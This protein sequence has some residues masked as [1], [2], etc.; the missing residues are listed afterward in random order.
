MRSRKLTFLP[1]EDRLTP[2]VGDL[3][4]TLTPPGGAVDFG[5]SVAASSQYVVVGAD[6]ANSWAG[7]AAVYDA[8][9]GARLWTFNDPAGITDDY[10]GTSVAVSG[11]LV[12]V[13]APGDDTSGKDTGR[14]YV[15]DATTGNLVSTLINPSPDPG[16]NPAEGFGDAV[17]ITGDTIFVSADEDPHPTLYSGNVYEF[18][19]STGNYLGALTP[20]ASAEGHNFGS[21]LAVTSSLLAVAASSEGNFTEGAVH[22]YDVATGNLLRTI[23]EPG[24]SQGVFD[25][26]GRSLSFSGT[27]LVI[28]APKRDLSGTDAGIAY[29]FDA[30]TGSLLQTLNNPHPASG[31]WF[32]HG[33]AI[34]GNTVIVGAPYDNTQASNN[35]QAYVFDASSGGV[36]ATIPNPV[37]SGTSG[38]GWSAAAASDKLVAGAYFSGNAYT[39]QGRATGG[40]PPQANNDTFQVAENSSATTL[41]V[42][43][44][45]TAD[46]AKLLTVSAITQPTHGSVTIS[47]DNK[48][49]QYTP[50]ANYIGADSFTYTAMDPNGSSTA[51]V[52]ITVEGPPQPKDDSYDVLENSSASTLDVL[53]ND[54]AADPSALT[55]SAVTQPSHGTVSISADSKSVTYKP[56][57]YYNGPDSFTYTA[58]D[59]NGSTIATVNITVDLV[60]NPP[61]AQ[62]DE[63]TVNQDSGANSLDVLAND[64]DPDYGQTVSVTQVTQGKHGTV[65][66]T[67][68]GTGL[69]YAPNSGYVGPD[70][71]TYTVSDGH[72]GTASTNVIVSVQQTGSS[73][74]PPDAKDDSAPNL[75]ENAGAQTID[76]LAN[77][78]DPDAADT[79]TV[80]TVTQGQHGTVAIAADGKSVTYAPNLEFVGSDSFLYS[81][82]DGHGGT[83]Y[84]AVTVTVNTDLHDRLEI[85]TS[86][87]ILTF[88]EGN[89][90]LQLDGGIRVSTNNTGIKK[91]QIKIT[92][93]YVKGRDVLTFTPQK[94]LKGSFSSATGTLT[95]SGLPVATAASAVNVLEGVKYKNA[96]ADPVAGV[97]T[98]AFTASD[99]LG[100]GDPAYRT[101]NVIAKNTPPTIVVT[102]SALNYKENAPALALTS[103][104]KITDLDNV[105]LAGATVAITGGFAMG[106]DVLSVA[107][108]PGIAG[109]YD[110]GS[111]S[112]TLTGTATLATYAN[113][114]KS[115]KYANT[116]DGPS[117]ATRTISFTATDGL[118]TSLAA[119]R[120]V[121]VI[122]V[123]DAPVLDGS[124]N[125][126][127]PN[128]NHDDANPAGVTVAAL[129]G[130]SVTDPDPGALQGIAVTSFTLVGGGTWQYSVDGTNWLNISFLNGKALLLAATDEIRYLPSGTT[131]GS[132]TITCRAWDQTSGRAGQLVSIRTE[133]GTSA[134]SVA[135][136][137]ATVGV[138]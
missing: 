113:V 115:V 61:V 52:N 41:D 59:S 71:F 38:F 126:S 121:N 21:A 29:I 40:N 94:G 105:T 30:S 10:F 99:S 84:A 19:A 64:S 102:G 95:L 53:N 26:F 22:I 33:V 74:N 44:N 76:V 4:H 32:G 43:A 86:P 110:A 91:L 129:L 37:T 1:L 88:T 83:D 109:A 16:Q 130:T 20:P 122:P 104:V 127:L 25:D 6:G 125:P 111:G 18:Q 2:S 49:V 81:I 116:S 34:S 137:T 11:N 87:G 79:L 112:L 100:T 54:V 114:L 136:A 50:S 7:L 58:H 12:V 77:D 69:S 132:A 106:Q 70:S 13:G 47:A 8:S 35:G 60:N 46:D 65:A 118:D 97:R 107:L 27:T 9:S 67:G 133:G 45:D 68:G 134:F 36:L 63:A 120:T 103:K 3:L 73:N 28:G 123:N 51:T 57:A 72:G 89:A 78:T 138:V 119:T 101:I 55:V 62:D 82:S 124:S 92:S 17:A 80:T 108:V 23:N 85:A 128:V 90:P 48:S 42:L 31:S 96:S 131:T 66:I 39:F 14:A 24:P 117:T 75:M 56:S 93:G 5:T 15:Y 98:L 135:L